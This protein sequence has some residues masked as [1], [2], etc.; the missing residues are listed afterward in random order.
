MHTPSTARRTVHDYFGQAYFRLARNGVRPGLR[1]PLICGPDGICAAFALETERDRITRVDYRCATCVTLV[2]LCEHLAE[3][4][5]AM[6][7]DEAARYKPRFL[8]DHHPEIPPERRDRAF[9]AVEAFRSAAQ[10][11]LRRSGA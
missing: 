8:L 1:G 11:R 6:T 10:D 7:V 9:V 3:L 5:S 4:A 2:A